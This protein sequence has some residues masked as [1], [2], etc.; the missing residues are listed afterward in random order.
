MPTYS[1]TERLAEI[2]KAGFANPLTALAVSLAE[3]GENRDVNSQGQS[4]ARYANGEREQ[5][6]GPW[7]IHLPAHPNVTRSCALDLTCS[8]A[9]AFKIS[10]G[11]TN[12]GAWSAFTNGSFERFMSEI[13]DLIPSPVSSPSPSGSSGSIGPVGPTGPGDSPITAGKNL[14]DDKPFPIPAGGCPK[15]WH[16]GNMGGAGFCVP[17]GLQF[18]GGDPGENIKNA[19]PDALKNAGSSLDFA[20][21]LI[22][23][24]NLWRIA[25]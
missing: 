8:T 19:L 13:R 18:G 3:F 7:Q 12:F 25:F 10:Q 23:P 14:L 4:D 11:G 16:S 5:S 1:R 15:G 22:A 21:A 24:D 17:D 20:K 2:Q 9:E 6:F